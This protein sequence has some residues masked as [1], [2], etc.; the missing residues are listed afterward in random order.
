MFNQVT[1]AGIVTKPQFDLSVYQPG[2][3][4]KVVC[5]GKKAVRNNYARNCL[6]TEATPLKLYLAYVD[7]ESRLVTMTIDI[8]E[9]IRNDKPA[10]IMILGEAK[11]NE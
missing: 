2:V 4:V 8:D 9:A 10:Y 5:Y 3:A 1:K 7:D 6:I 11:N